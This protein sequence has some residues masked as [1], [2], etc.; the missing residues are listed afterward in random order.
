MGWLSY[1]VE[2]FGPSTGAS[3][4]VKHSADWPHLCYLISLFM[5]VKRIEKLCEGISLDTF[6]FLYNSYSTLKIFRHSSKASSF[7]IIMEDAY[8]EVYKKIALNTDRFN[9]GDEEVS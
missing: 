8:E 9:L 5:W 1:L 2:V 3:A 7:V 4:D 6:I